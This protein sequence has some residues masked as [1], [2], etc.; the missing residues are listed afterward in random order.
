MNITNHIIK[1]LN[2]QW[3][4]L[5]SILLMIQYYILWI[6]SYVGVLSNSIYYPIMYASSILYLSGLLILLLRALINIIITIKNNDYFLLT[7]IIAA[8]IFI[9]L[10]A[11]LSYI[12]YLTYNSTAWDLGIFMQALYTTA[13]Y[14]KP[15]YYTAELYVNPSGSF[16]GTHFSPILFTLVP[17]YYLSPH[18]L[19]LLAIQATLVYGAA[20]PLYLIAKNLT[21]DELVS[22]II[23]LIYLLV[24]GLSGIIYFD[25]HVEAFIPLIYFLFTYYLSLIHI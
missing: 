25:F 1:E 24:P 15:L 7:T 3:I 18:A 6:L 11:A 9:A 23:A 16:L 17:I 8:I 2:S 12:K 19:T 14:H 4:M 10:S 22:F 13:Y 5:I 20:I 21:K